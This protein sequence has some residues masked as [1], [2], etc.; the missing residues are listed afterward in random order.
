MVNNIKSIHLSIHCSLEKKEYVGAYVKVKVTPRQAYVGTEGRQR[1]SSKPFTTS[2]L[3][4]SGWVDGYNNAPAALHLVKTW[5]PMYRRLGGPQGHLDG[6]KK[7]CPCW[8]SI[9]FPSNPCNESLY[10]HR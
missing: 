2:M 5:Y 7:S 3:E 10:L 6:P 1:Y 9:P 4:G 8:E